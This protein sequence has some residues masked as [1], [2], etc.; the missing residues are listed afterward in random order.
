MDSS[1]KEAL[2]LALFSLGIPEPNTSLVLRRL[3]DNQQ[4]DGQLPPDGSLVDDQQEDD[5]LYPGGSSFNDNT[6]TESVGSDPLVCP[7]CHKSF[8]QKGSRNRHVARV[9]PEKGR[10]KKEP[11]ATLVIYCVPCVLTYI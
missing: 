6:T 9:H 8:T 10:V 11:I 3:E 1:D 4:E 5:K 2:L 7:I